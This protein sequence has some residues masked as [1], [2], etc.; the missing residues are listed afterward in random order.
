[1]RLRVKYKSVSFYVSVFEVSKR[2]SQCR[3]KIVNKLFL[4][5]KYNLCIE[6]M[7]DSYVKKSHLVLEK[8][9]VTDFRLA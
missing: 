6:K 7:D 4:C 3:I 2:Q 8:L 5:H 1:M 9:Y